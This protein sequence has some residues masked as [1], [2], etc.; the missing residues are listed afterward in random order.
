MGVLGLKNCNV[1]YKFIIFQ[2]LNWSVIIYRLINEFNYVL[3]YMS[4]RNRKTV[5]KSL[6]IA[7]KMAHNYIFNIF[8]VI[9]FSML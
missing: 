2:S 7:R 6:F 8:T 5:S 9:Y 3:I 1:I 4:Y